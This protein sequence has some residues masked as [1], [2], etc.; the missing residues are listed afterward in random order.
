M[1]QPKGYD[2]PVDSVVNRARIVMDIKTPSS[3]MSRGG[4]RANLPKLKRTDEVK[5]V[6]ASEEDYTWARELVKGRNIP[7][8]EILFSP[9]VA[10]KGM[11]GNFSAVQ[12]TWLAEKILEDRLPV[13]LQ[14]QLH[15]LLWGADR[16]GV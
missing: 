5:F 2:S 14:I 1:A 13:R 11:P 16:K 4:F 3:Q 7:T 12:A 10:A 8:E 9:A 6:I 15:K